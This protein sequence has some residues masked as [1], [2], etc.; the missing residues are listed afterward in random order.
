MIARL[1]L[2]LSNAYLIR[3]EIPV[4]VDTGAE[5]DFK[6]LECVLA[7]LNIDFQ[8]IGL[9]VITHA[10]YDHV[11]NLAR[12]RKVADVPAIAH[13]QELPYLSAGENSPS[14][15]R[16]FGGRILT[17][18]FYEKFVP[19][20]PEAFLEEEEMSLTPFGIPGV[21][22]H[23]PGHTAGSLSVL[24]DSGDAIVG[25]LIMGGFLGGH[26]L[27]SRP[28]YPYGATDSKTIV[29]QVSRLLDRGAQR[30]LPGH[31]GP[32]YRNAMEKW[33]KRQR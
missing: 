14:P 8:Q 6:K 27:P 18:M 16:N 5:S 10:H 9:I 24:L 23:T 19:F 11:G 12:I 7:K 30:F 22:M 15:V 20:M 26:I 28:G 25:D 31:G 17:S 32:I 4:L 33:I 21:I 13:Q 3:G 29:Q 2:T 1:P